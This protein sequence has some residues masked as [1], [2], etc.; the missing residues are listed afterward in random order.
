MNIL[1]ISS[2]LCGGLIVMAALIILIGWALSHAPIDEDPEL[3]RPQDWLD[4]DELKP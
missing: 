2:L 4:E 3:T 1:A